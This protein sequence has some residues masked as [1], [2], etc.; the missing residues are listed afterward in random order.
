MKRTGKKKKTKGAAVAAESSGITAT[1]HASS[2]LSGKRGGAM[3]LN[4]QHEAVQLWIAVI[5]LV[6][7]VVATTS[8]AVG[9]GRWA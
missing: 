8:A 3:G 6:L 1:A 4:N 7:C 2:G 9:G 5:P